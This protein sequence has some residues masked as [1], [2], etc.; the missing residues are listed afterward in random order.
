MSENTK[1]GKHTCFYVSSF[2]KGNG[3]RR[4]LVFSNGGEYILQRG[5]RTLKDSGATFIF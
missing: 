3:R 4:G 5:D 2:S 1:G